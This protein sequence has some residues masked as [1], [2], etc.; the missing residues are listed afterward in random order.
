MAR[1]SEGLLHGP[2][3]TE[4]LRHR[5]WFEL[6]QALGLPELPPISLRK[7]R[8]DAAAIGVRAA[9]ILKPSVI[10][11]R[12]IADDTDPSR[13]GTAARKLLGA[14]PKLRSRPSEQISFSDIVAAELKTLIDGLMA[15]DPDIG[16]DPEVAIAIRKGQVAL[17]TAAAAGGGWVAFAAA[18]GSAGFAPY[19]VAAKLSA[20]I[21]FVSGPALVSLLAVMI[22]PVTV[23]AGTTALGYLAIKGHGSSASAVAA[24]R[25][26]VLL[27]VS[28]L[29]DQERGLAALVTDFR[30]CHRLS[31]DDLTHLSRRQYD[32]LGER[33]LQ[34]EKR[35]KQETIPAVSIAPRAWAMPLKPDAT[36]TAFVG[37]L[38]TGDFLYHVSAVE[39]AVLLAIDFSRAL[40]VD[41]PLDLAVH[42]SSLASKGAQVS[43]RGYTAEQLVM[44]KLIDQGH[45]VELAAGS[46]MP[47]YDLIVDGN[48]VQVKCGANL[49]LLLEHFEKYPDIPVIADIDLATKAEAAGA[50]WSHLVSSVD[51][52]E[53]EYVQAMVDRSLNAA[54]SIGEAAVPFY[55]ALVGGARGARR[56]WKGEISIEDLPPWL[57]VDLSIR[58]GL[59]TAGHVSGAFVGFLVIGPAGALVLGPV[60]GIAALLGTSRIHGLV[61]RSIRSQWHDDVMAAAEELRT[62]LITAWDRRIDLILERQLQLRRAGQKTPDDLMTWLEGRTLDDAISVCESLD[63]FRRVS[64]LRSAMELLVVAATEVADPDVSKARRQLATLIEAKPSTTDSLSRIGGKFSTFVTEKLGKH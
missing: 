57:V 48:P 51:G 5:L 12:K 23:I 37:A 55:A 28:G 34:V 60:V 52:F 14:L 38:T 4:A 30:R 8:T 10:V 24:A 2:S 19:I 46:T 26:A 29:Q 20:V 44:T 1:I 56:A 40:T 61:D 3:S 13:T 47:G 53:L 43:I 16:F 36:D 27:A 64:T 32:E 7:V 11:A 41:N 25:V 15:A 59:A 49:S 62:S 54:E 21:P 35:L 45:V 58:G 50:A 17:A 9:E 6:A 33:A 22:N 39:P 42:V 18:V 31:R 63:G